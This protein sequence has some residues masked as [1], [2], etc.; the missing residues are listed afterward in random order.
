GVAERDAGLA[1]LVHEA[2]VQELHV[3]GVPARHARALELRDHL[4]GDL[5][6]VAS[7]GE[8]LRGR[9]ALLERCLDVARVTHD[10]RRRGCP[11]QW[12]EPVR[13]T[14]VEQ[15][16]RRWRTARLI[17]AL[18]KN[19]ALAESKRKFRSRRCMVIAGDT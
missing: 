11:M 12:C 15:A 18:C 1:A 2:R 9:L 6:L 13:N 17:C 10:A 5:P 4:A 16:S 19:A 8:E 14:D 7:G 3:V